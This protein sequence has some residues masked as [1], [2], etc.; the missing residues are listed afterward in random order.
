MGLTETWF[1]PNEL[2]TIKSALQ[3]H[4][5]FSNDYKSYEIFSKSGM[6]EIE[7]DYSGRP[8][9]GVSVIIKNNKYFTCKEIENLSDRIVSVGIYDGES[10][11][12]QVICCTYMPF[13]NGNGD[14]TDLYVE[15]IDALQAVVD[16]YASTAP[17]KIIGDLNA[18]LPTNHKL[19]KN[20]FKQGNF[21]IYSNILYDFLIFND[22]IAADLLQKQIVNYTYFCH[23]NKYYTWIDH[24]ICERRDEKNITSCHIIPEEPGN[25]SDHLPVQLKFS[26]SIS[27]K[28]KQKVISHNTIHP[29]WTNHKN[30]E[31]Y[32]KLVTEECS[33]MAPIC[34]NSLNDSNIKYKI[35]QR[36]E[37]INNI[38]ITATKQS[39]CIPQKVLKA[40]TYWCPELS[41][42][43]DKKRIW[44]SIWISLGRPRE[45]LIFTILKDLKKKFR[46]LSRSNI[47]TLAMKDTNL[48]NAQFK[49][50]N[51]SIIWN[52]LKMNK[53][54]KVNSDL[55]AEEFES[56]FSAL[57]KDI[58]PLN[59]EQLRIQRSVEER[60]SYL[61]RMKHLPYKSTDCVLHECKECY[62]KSHECRENDTV[63]DHI[64]IISGEYILNAIKHLKKGTSPGMDCISSEHLIHAISPKLAD[65]LANVYSIMISSGTIPEIFQKSIIVPILKK[66]TLDSNIPTNYR[67]IALSSVHTKLVEE[68]LMPEDKA[69][70]NQFGF[71]KGRGTMF[72]TSLL[73]DIS[74]YTTAHGSPLYVCSLDAEKCFDSI[75]HPGL[76]YKLMHIIPDAQWLFLYNWYAESYAQ[77]RWENRLSTQFQITKGM[78]QGSKLSPVLF[79]IFINDLLLKLKPMNSGV[80]IHD[81]HINVLAYADDLNLI[82]TTAIGLQKLINICY[83]YAQMWRMRFNPLKTSIVCVG[84]QPHINPPVWTLGNTQVG[85]SEEALILGVTI[86]STLSSNKH[87][88]NRMRKCQQSMFKMTPMGLSYPGL[89]SDVKAFLWNSICCP[90]LVYGMESIAI[91]EKDLKSLKTTQGNIIKRI[92]GIK[93]RSHHSK[94]LKALKIPVIE[95][96]ITKNSLRL[97]KNIFKT[98]TPARDLQ[99]VLLARY[100]IKGNITKGTLLEKVVK[101]GCDPLQIIFDKQNLTGSDHDVIEQDNGVTDSLSFLLHHEDYNKPW[102]KEHILATLLTKAF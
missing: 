62:T 79:N 92:M 95:D 58:E 29:N 45:G 86:N 101:A 98:D 77:V 36:L 64:Y 4:P 52:K 21:N 53:K 12:I 30:V 44:W 66:A 14:Q 51:M 69:S 73:N 55:N 15:T 65:L 22:F 24:I 68:A 25:T 70:G 63:T 71:R 33:K 74:A 7:A 100:I 39:G 89:N 94:L 23:E 87:V 38:L 80:K 28:N 13:Y 59:A 91:S 60:S 32:S 42:L 88:K 61:T 35:D 41:Q 82:S 81:F 26:I 31:K 67:P 83:Q 78:K 8:F 6:T 75:W 56:H 5:N 47:N 102:S 43:R 20:W 17:I 1:R 48:I 50:R 27:G 84:K 3:N 37:Q 9:G 93:K 54:F 40:K 46:K 90:I 11:L 96:V 97:Y 2:H 19:A 49:E 10:N 57:S 18:Q 34:I 99:S 76:H 85:L 72:A 16:Q